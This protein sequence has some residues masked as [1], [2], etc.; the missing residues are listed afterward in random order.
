MQPIVYQT[1]LSKL[2][3]GGVVD[4]LHQ[5]DEL[6]PCLNQIIPLLKENGISGKVLRHCELKE[7]KNVLKL[8]F[9]PWEI[10]QL[11]VLTLRSVEK[12]G[13]HLK[14]LVFEGAAGDGFDQ[15]ETG[16]LPVGASGVVTLSNALVRPKSQTVIE[17]QVRI[18][19]ALNE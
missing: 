17:K 2:N 1:K 15:I 5:V 10:F 8:P 18:Y 16:P 14:G 4:I 9:G 19:C 11:L 7:L 6:R 13:D 3:V 12:S